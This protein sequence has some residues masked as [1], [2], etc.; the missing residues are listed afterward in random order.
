[1][2]LHR[3]AIGSLL[4]AQATEFNVVSRRATSRGLPTLLPRH[5][6][7]IRSVMFFIGSELDDVVCCVLMFGS[8][9]LFV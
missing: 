7:K 4:N 5:G 3:A 9:F 2:F 8:G 6:F 1:M